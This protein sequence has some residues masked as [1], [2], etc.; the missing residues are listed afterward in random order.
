MKYLINKTYLS[1]VPRWTDNIKDEWINPFI[2]E[3]CELDF[4]DTISTSLYNAIVNLIEP[5]LAGTQGL[6][7]VDADYA[8]NDIVKYNDVYYKVI[9]PVI[10]GE[11]P[12]S[13]NINFEVSELINFWANYVVDFIAYSTYR[14]FILW[15]G[16]HVSQGGMRKHNDNTSFEISAEELSYLMADLRGPISIKQSL[17]NNELSNVNYTF[18][19]VVYAANTNIKQPDY[20]IQIFAV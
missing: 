12:P 4:R 3:S 11:N 13:T 14:K 9:N 2:K 6:N 5:I 10:T 7:W 17:L 8:V 18:D 15:H 19:G 1:V 20:D 16:K